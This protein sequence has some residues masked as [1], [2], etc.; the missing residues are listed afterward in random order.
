MSRVLSDLRGINNV[1][2][3]T[4]LSSERAEG[5]RSS[6][7]Q[8]A[9]ES[10]YGVWRIRVFFLSQSGNEHPSVNNTQKHNYKTGRMPPHREVQ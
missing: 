9:M 2:G 4:Q 1:D 5:K 8:R 3:V 6:D 7:N 10:I